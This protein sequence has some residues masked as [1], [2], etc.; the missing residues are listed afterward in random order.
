MAQAVTV[1]SLL[2][3]HFMNTGSITRSHYFQWKLN[4]RSIFGK[5]K[6]LKKLI[7][8]LCYRQSLLNDPKSLGK[9]HDHTA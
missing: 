8:N 7:N 1:Y 5:K 4:F 6:S 3:G 2:G 9:T